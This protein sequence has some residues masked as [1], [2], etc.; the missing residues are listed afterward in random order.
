MDVLCPFASWRPLGTVT[1]EPSIGTPR[2]V[3]VHTM[4]GGL[5]GTER[6]FKTGNG[7]GYSGTESTFGLGGPHDGTLDGVLYQW[8]R[9]DR[10]ADAQYDANAWA[11]S[12]ETS[13]G[14]HPSEPWSDKQLA[15]LVRLGVWW[16]RQTG[17]PA[18]L[19]TSPTGVGFG[20]HR[21]FP[22]WNRSGHS[23]PGDVRQN[24]FLK[25]VLPRIHAAL[26]TPTP[27]PT[28]P[29]FPLPSTSWFGPPSSDPRNHSGYYSVWDRNHFVGWQRQMAA[30]GWKI[31]TDGLFSDQTHSVVLAFQHEKRLTANGHV[32]AAT[33]RAA[34]TAKVT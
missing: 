8:Q 23:C 14:G 30:R 21:Q 12:V 24:Q 17:R 5:L 1:D 3:I 6:Y 22:E 28:F 32:D 20:Y 27:A 7:A 19:A 34:W 31:N 33:W 15:S 16:C 13:D 10:Q 4:V 9:L 18:T 11:T 26:S 25:V 29:A 2:L